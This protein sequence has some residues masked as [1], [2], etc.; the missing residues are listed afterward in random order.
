MN[1]NEV[2]PENE[3]IEDKD[4]YMAKMLIIKEN[5]N[6]YTK[7]IKY[8]DQVEYLGHMKNVMWIKM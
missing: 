4:I 8:E 1:K 6:D 3:L 7:V 5:R 2:I